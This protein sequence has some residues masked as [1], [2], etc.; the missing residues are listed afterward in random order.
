[1]DPKCPGASIL[2]VRTFTSDVIGGSHLLP[3]ALLLRQSDTVM[4]AVENFMKVLFLTYDV[5]RSYEQDRE[6]V[7]ACE[8]I[9]QSP[10]H[11]SPGV[12]I[13]QRGPVH[14]IHRHRCTHAL[15]H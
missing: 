11:P 6:H 15:E 14:Q 7:A 10:Q 13:R 12:A 4:V 9:P 2:T 1:M 8:G 5:V 3:N